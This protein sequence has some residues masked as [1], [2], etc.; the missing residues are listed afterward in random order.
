MINDLMSR[1]PGFHH[2]IIYDLISYQDLRMC[3]D[4]GA[5]GGI[6]TQRI[7]K[8]GS[9][10]TTIVAFEPFPGNH[11]Y[12]SQNTQG[13]DGVT[14]IKKAVSD[15]TGTATFHVP[16]VVQG[17]EKL[18]GEMLG[19]SSVGFLTDGF[20]SERQLLNDTPDASE[21]SVETVAISDVISSHV[22]FMKMDIQGGEFNALQGCKALIK[23]HG[24]D[25]IYIEFDGDARVLDFLAENG[26]SIFDTDYLLLPMHGDLTKVKEA[27]FSDFQ[28]V[29]LSTGH[30][31]Y[32]ARLRLA[33]RDYSS[34]F[35]YFRQY[36]GSIYTDLICVSDNF[37]PQFLINLGK[38]SRSQSTVQQQEINSV[39]LDNNQ[40]P[41]VEAGNDFLS[42]L[43]SFFDRFVN[44]YYGYKV[45]ILALL[46]VGL[47]MVAPILPTPY[48]WWMMSSSTI[49]LFVVLGKISYRSKMA[50]AEMESL[51]VA[52]KQATHNLRQ[53]LRGKVSKS[54]YRKHLRNR[55][56]RKPA[57]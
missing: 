29:N 13:H 34:F 56:R 47:S 23:E 38:Y 44:H 39:A 10:K 16:S 2:N 19:Y 53:Q 3:L 21:F 22:D 55:H 46:A 26:Y 37:L 30:S 50:L 45:F 24:I 27:G 1:L 12:F 57:N 15:C 51:K 4:V 5:A 54:V 35:D 42:W 49:I 7:L 14:L 8:A 6:I 20:G 11:Q 33:D 25:V 9:E 43:K 31:A 32:Y 52:H 48:C 17:T 36:H 40:V 28:T 18:Y 41:S